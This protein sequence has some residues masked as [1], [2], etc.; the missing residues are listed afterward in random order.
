MLKLS[1]AAVVAIRVANIS[2]DATA[3]GCL[4]VDVSSSL[5][6][7]TAAASIIRGEIVIRR[8]CSHTDFTA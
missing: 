2:E 5:S 6:T 3:V 8:V 4:T 7:A 1:G